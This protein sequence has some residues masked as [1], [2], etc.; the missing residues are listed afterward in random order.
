MDCSVDNFMLLLF[1]LD[2]R[3]HYTGGFLY[4]YEKN[5]FILSKSYLIKQ[6]RKYFAS[7]KKE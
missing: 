1:A 5:Q 7:E 6:H 3:I 4:L 2:P